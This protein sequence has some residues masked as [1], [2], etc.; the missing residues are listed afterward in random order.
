ML[1]LAREVNEKIIIGDEPNR[2]V[3]TVTKIKMGGKARKVWLGFE[4]PRHINIAREEV[5]EPGTTKPTV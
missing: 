5:L 2:I 3:I 4:A 1:V